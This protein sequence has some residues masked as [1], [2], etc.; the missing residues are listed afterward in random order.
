MPTMW[1][2]NPVHHK[3]WCHIGIPVVL[4]LWG[5][6][7]GPHI[8]QQNISL[9]NS[10][11]LSYCICVIALNGCSIYYDPSSA[12]SCVWQGEGWNV[13]LLFLAT[14]AVFGG[15][16]DFRKHSSCTY[17]GSLQTTTIHIGNSSMAISFL[18]GGIS[19]RMLSML[20]GLLCFPPYGWVSCKVMCLGREKG[21]SKGGLQTGYY[22]KKS[23]YN[24]EQLG[25]GRAGGIKFYFKASLQE[26]FTV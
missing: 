23:S 18:N 8:N 1:Q 13:I 3:P 14:I 10:Y 21:S 20:S 6:H 12:V 11:F 25:L 26:P 19:L 16:G 17:R 15:G 5:T 4:L 7:L 22:C 2:H 24:S 9:K